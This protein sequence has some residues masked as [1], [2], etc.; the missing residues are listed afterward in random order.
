MLSNSVILL[1][2]PGAILCHGTQEPEI[3][4]RP[5][6]LEKIFHKYIHP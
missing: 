2:V 1:H 3:L 6:T 5:T 4:Y